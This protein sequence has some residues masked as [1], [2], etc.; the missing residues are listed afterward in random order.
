MF[1]HAYMHAHMLLHAYDVVHNVSET[2]VVPTAVTKTLMRR[3][4]HG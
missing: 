3:L 4:K 2:A 1:T